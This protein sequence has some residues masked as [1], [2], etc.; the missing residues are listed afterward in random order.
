MKNL[1]KL[2]TLLIAVTLST[3]LM[4]QNNCLEFDGT[5][6]YVSV[7]HNSVFNWGS[8]AF[9]VSAWFKT[10]STAISAIVDKDW[11]GMYPTGWSLMLNVNGAGTATF[12]IGDGSNPNINVTGGS[13]LNDDKWHQVVA[14]RSA[15][16]SYS[17]F[18]D[19]VNV[20]SSSETKTNI[21]NSY[22]IGIGARAS[23][24][25][26]FYFSG[27]IDE[28]RIWN[29][30]R[31]ETEI[32][33]YMYQ[34]ISPGSDLVAYYKLNSTSGT[35]ATDEKGSNN[36]T[37]YNMANDDWLTSSAFFGPKNC[38]DFDG[39]NDYVNIADNDALDLT[40]DY[41][42]EAWVKPASL[43][44]LDGIIS[45]YQTEATNGYYIRLND[46][47]S[48]QFDNLATASGVLTTGTWY[49][50]AGVNDDGTRHLYVN[51]VEQSITGTALNIAINTDPLRIGTDY[52][53]RY[54]EG[55]ID[56]VRIWNDVRSEDEIIENMHNNLTS[57]ETNLVAY[58]NFDNS[59]G[60]TLQN[61]TSTTLDG[62]LTTMDAATD[63]VSSTAFNTWLNTDDE[64][65]SETTNWSDGGIPTSSDNVGIPNYSGGSQPTITTALDCNNLVVGAG[66]ILTDGASVDHSASKN[67]IVNG[68]IDV[69]AGNLLDVGKS[70]IITTTGEL[71]V[72]PLGKVTVANKLK[73]NG[74]GTLTLNSSSSG[75]ASL[76][77]NGTATGSVIQ[78]RY[79]AAAEWGTWNDG[80]HFLSSPVANYAI[81]SNFTTADPDDYD[82]YAWS[83]PYN[84]WVNYKD[85]TSPTF[86]EA[87]GGSTTFELGY[88]YLAAYADTDTKNFTG[89]INVA[90]VGI[91]GLTITGSGNHRSWHLLGNPFNSGLTWFTGWTTNEK[92]VTTAKIWNGSGKSYSDIASGSIIPA[93]NGFMVQASGGIGTLTIPA[94]KRTHDGTFYK[95]AEFPIIK[96][97]AHNLD[98]PSFQE[99]Q[100]RFNPESSNEWDMEFDSD[101][102]AGYAP[103]FYSIVEGV[104]QSVNSMPNLSQATTIH[105]TF[106]KN[107]GVNF[108]IEMYE[109]ENMVMDV[110]LLDKKLNNNHNLSQNPVYLFTAF[111]QDD[112]ERFVIQFAPVGINEE[113]SI[114]SNIQTWAANKTIHILNPENSKGEIRILN[115]FGQQ[116]AQARLTGDTK[117]SIQLNIP[118]GCY[119][120]S[121]VSGEEVVTR[122][123]IMK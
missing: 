7:P 99:S 97:K 120:V 111:E 89:T 36:G 85:G 71:D 63:W 15:T 22:A 16:N 27:R 116:V 112:P 45:K 77:V 39:T 43:G 60:T 68:Y 115:L 57:N 59:A 96:L 93:T 4:A 70:L 12:L 118:T 51:G 110:W 38:L 67:I 81:A 19:G 25:N 80:W 106:I 5:N 10:S 17:L 29:D 114:K 100:L 3:S 91:T 107:E 18:I 42:L 23:R 105:F 103:Y 92:I 49:H 30:A 88:G 14:V 41:T 69:K 34:E 13:N 113:A 48:L 28:V 11:W 44:A 76:I 26:A 54:F 52:S 6:D 56:E 32:R 1:Y 62:T 98:N 78:E 65:W 101:F 84:I 117:Q 109:V 37:L 33:Q 53:S 73:I 75:D 46:N 74:S 8:G 21:D 104:P 102:L 82:F 20:G 95:N 35:T 9:S 58:Y 86:S 2:T 47:G 90:D 87:N 61:F 24:D 64:S 121:I 122:K 40:N 119:L 55:Q 31:T 94:A 72:K 79:I 50:V 83:E 66:A 123:V 108:C